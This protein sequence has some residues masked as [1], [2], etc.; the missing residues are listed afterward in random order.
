MDSLV[1]DPEYFPQVTLSTPI[2]IDWAGGITHANVQHAVNSLLG[3]HF[4]H[5]SSLPTKS[6]DQDDRL[7]LFNVLTDV[8]P[9]M[10]SRTKLFWTRAGRPFSQML[11]TA[12]MSLTTQCTYLVFVYARVL[13][14][15]PDKGTGPPACLTLDGSPIEFSWIIPRKKIAKGHANRDVRII[16]EPFD[17][18]GSGYMLKGSSVLEYFAS[19]AGS[20][21]GVVQ[22]DW[23]GLLWVESAEGLF[24]PQ[25]HKGD[26]IQ[27]GGR[28]LVGLDF[29]SSGFVTL[30]AYVLSFEHAPWVRSVEKF[31]SPSPVCMTGLNLSP[32]RTLAG[33]IYPT[34]AE[35]FD[36]LMGYINSLEPEQRHVYHFTSID[37]KSPK[38][39]RLKI[40]VLTL[41]RTNWSS[42]KE[43][44]TLGGRMCSS[45]LDAALAAFESFWN[46]M[47]PESSSILDKPLRQLPIDVGD[48]HHPQG[49]LAYQYEFIPGDSM[50]FPKI[51]VPV[52]DGAASRALED[53][54]NSNGIQGPEGGEQGPGWVE[55][56][57]AKSY[58]YRDLNERNGCRT[59]ISFGLKKSGWE[60]TSYFSPEIFASEH[61]KINPGTS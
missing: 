28:F 52:S 15:L 25:E 6:V 49:G 31:K 20:L 16:M 44:F 43:D 61:D 39:N 42:I 36:V 5:S 45:Q 29:S 22:C 53:F 38:D 26:Y 24:F 14:F 48:N 30:K 60:V 33:N 41:T 32:L 7:A 17:P 8:L 11:H 34:F 18:R 54:Y 50:L 9:S 47:F 19:Y 27:D 57:V 51:Y 37:C 12:Q 40:Y 3:R 59:Y 2:D 46:C 56:E 1:K 10:S 4:V 21:G 13:G 35:S 58:N 55:R 23:D